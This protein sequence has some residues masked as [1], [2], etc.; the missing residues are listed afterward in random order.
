MFFCRF[1]VKESLD[2]N[3]GLSVLTGAKGGYLSV[4]ENGGILLNLFS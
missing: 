1:S 3:D 2:S 4:M